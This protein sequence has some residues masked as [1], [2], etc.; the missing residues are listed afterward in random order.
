VSG[1][2]LDINGG[3]YVPR[4]QKL[5]IIDNKK[6]CSTCKEWLPLESYSKAKEYYSSKCPSCV[7]I[8]ASEYRKK[9]ENKIKRQQ[10]HKS[11]MEIKENRDAKNKYIREYRKSDKAK[12]VNYKSNRMWLKNEK[13][14]AVDYKGG[15]CIKCGY[16]KCLSALEFHHI[17]PEEKEGYNSHWTFER[18]KI[19]LNKCVLLCANCHREIHEIED[20]L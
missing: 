9:E 14:K 3:V 15:K 7:K 6:Q 12:N 16:K 11:Y 4:G 17:N 2:N 19:E 1:N 13:Q 20:A 5:K 8:Y 10:Y 18:N